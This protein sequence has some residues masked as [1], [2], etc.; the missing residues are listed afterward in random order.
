MAVSSFRTWS[1]ETLNN[2]WPDSSAHLEEQWPQSFLGLKAEHAMAGVLGDSKELPTPAPS[3]SGRDV[4][5]HEVIVNKRNI[6]DFCLCCGSRQVYTQHPLFEGGLC[7]P[8]KDRFLGSLFLYD[9]D[10]YQRYCTVCCSGDTLLICEDIDCTRC[11]C[12]ECMDILVGPGTSERIHAMDYWACFLCLPFARNGL[13]L[14]RRKWRQQLKDFQLKEKPGSLEVFKTVPAWKREPIRVLSL[15]GDIRKELTSL[16]FLESGSGS[17]E[18]K[19]KYLDDVTDVVRRDVG[20]WGPFDL[21]YGSTQ[22]R[23]HSCHNC[24]AW[25]MYQF[26]RILQ[27]AQPNS[28]SQQPFFWMFADNLLLSDED[29]RTANRFFEMQ[30]VILQDVCDRVPQ[31]AVRVWS[32]IPALRSRHMALTPEEEESLKA[33]VKAKAKLAVQ[34]P[35]SLVKN[36]FLPLRE[37]FK[38]FSENSLP[39]YP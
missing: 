21:M 11:Y 37:Y 6:E 22:P 8:C 13:L 26:H 35:P 29:V 7:I 30:F 23:S 5:P 25:Y 2:S 12:F 27:Y 24:P 18:G 1:L 17:E 10:G 31:N 39:P 19:L 9:D 14:R 20:K 32:N 15:F 34:G 36:C 16:G 38:Y 33:Q 28:K 3:P 4:I